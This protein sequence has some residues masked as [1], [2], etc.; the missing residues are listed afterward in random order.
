M[1]VGRQGF[2]GVRTGHTGASAGNTGQDSRASAGLSCSLALLVQ[3]YCLYL[4]IWDTCIFVMS[5]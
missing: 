3:S 2:V 5:S 1:K 4:F